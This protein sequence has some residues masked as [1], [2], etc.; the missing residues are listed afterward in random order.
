MTVGVSIHILYQGPRQCEDKLPFLGYNII[1][2]TRAKITEIKV[3]SLMC[4]PLNCQPYPG[5]GNAM[6]HAHMAHNLLKRRIINL[7]TGPKMRPSHV[8][9]CRLFYDEHFHSASKRGSPSKMHVFRV[10]STFSTFR[11]LTVNLSK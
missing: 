2:E 10:L 8:I 4:S 9:G 6:R 3:E 11:S 7:L 1:T 5:I